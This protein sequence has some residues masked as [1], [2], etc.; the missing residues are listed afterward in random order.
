[1]PI[2]TGIVNFSRMY[3]IDTITIDS[4]GG[5]H[6]DNT[7]TLTNLAQVNPS[8]IDPNALVNDANG[9]GELNGVDIITTTFP[10][11]S[12]TTDLDRVDLFAQFGSIANSFGSGVHY[13][14]LEDPSGQQYILFSSSFDFSRIIGGS[15]TLTEQGDAPGNMALE[16]ILCFARGTLLATP[17]GEIA[18]ENLRVGTKLRTYQ[19]GL[20]TARFIA[21]THVSAPML[22][23]HPKLAPMR[24]KAGALGAGLP[25]QDLLVSRQHRI[26]LQSRVAERVIGQTD[27]LVPAIHLTQKNR[28]EPETPEGGISYYHI[29]TDHHQILI[30]NGAPCE[31]LYIGEQ[32]E[33]FLCKTDRD[34]IERLFD[35][36]HASPRSDVPII[37]NALAKTI[38]ARIRKNGKHLIERQEARL[39]IA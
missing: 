21:H 27:T 36:G 10:G 35:A 14:I 9:N 6:P 38:I 11:S 32:T 33:S 23:N 8:A 34:E 19:G 30:A 39:E 15:L 1:M 26:L 7:M 16:G 22:R 5:T 13:A 4:F 28:I 29:L 3:T 18:V 24:I 37:P 20:T 12:T 31:S 17:K 25:L 2:E